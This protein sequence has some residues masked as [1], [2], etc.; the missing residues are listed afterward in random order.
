[1]GKTVPTYRIA[2]EFEIEMWKGFRKALNSQE[3]HQA[4]DELMDMCRNNAMASGNACNP[5]IFEPMAM[6][7][8]LAQQ[9]KL[10]KLEYKLCEVIWQ[11]ICAE[12]Q[13]RKQNP[14][15]Q[16]QRKPKLLELGF[17]YVTEV[18]GGKLFRKRKSHEH[19]NY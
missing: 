9:K 17:E 3:E 18:K 5:V 1:M 10:M 11:K 4:F 7:I 15:Q 6:S 12:N 14:D 16:K 8:L 13:D 19:E 2:L